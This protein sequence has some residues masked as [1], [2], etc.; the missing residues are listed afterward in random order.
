LQ[1]ATP[2]Q[3]NTGYSGIIKD[4]NDEDYYK[5][6]LTKAG[7]IT[8]SADRAVDLGWNFQVMDK[9]GNRFRS[10]DTK[11]GNNVAGTENIELGLDKGEYYIKVSN[12]SS[13][14]KPY[15]FQVKFKESNYYEKE[16]NNS[17]QTATP[18]ELN[19]AYQGNLQ[20]DNYNH[21]EDWY[22]YSLVKPGNVSVKIDRVAGSSWVVEVLDK[23]G[24]PFT[25]VVTKYDSYASGQET[26]D[27]AL[28]TGQFYIR[29][30]HYTGTERVNY[31][32]IVE[33]T[34]SE[35]YE[36]EFNN[37][38]SS[39]NKVELNQT[40][41]GIIQDEVY[42]EVDFYTFSLSKAGFI[43][44]E[45]DRKANAGWTIEVLDKNGS[46]LS[47]K[48]T[49][50]GSN[51]NGKEQVNIGLPNG[52]Y[53]IKISNYTSSEGIPYSFK[54]MYEKGEFFKREINDDAQT[55][56]PIV[57]NQPYKRLIQ[58]DLYGLDY[59]TFTLSKKEE[60]LFSMKREANKRWE[61]QI[62]NQD[63]NE[64]DYFY[65][66]DKNISNSTEQRDLTLDKGTY[67][68]KITDYYGT[69]NVPYTFKI[70]QKTQRIQGASR[71]DTAIEISKQGWTT[72]NTVVL[73][74]GSDFP[75]ALAGGPLAYYHNVPIL[76]TDGKALTAVTK[77]EI[78][79]LN[80]K[81]VI[82]LG[83]VGAISK[84]VEDELKKSGV[85]I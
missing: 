64:L 41:K 12:Y 27:V 39:A 52:D 8:V 32:F 71:Y 34:Q 43:T 56:N 78:S 48:H 70:Q 79:R 6:T 61:I 3:L 33:F 40:Y 77:K 17:L 69:E 74:K 1:S 19:K 84:A 30:G 63:G 22:T 65:T 53:F 14:L 4:Y 55:A 38:L 24:K 85:S 26:V 76:L 81:K 67:F 16:H 15:Q 2:I 29:I 47:E 28:P 46:V 35:Y 9:E 5:F 73:A 83:S 21:E 57:I 23:T 31:K 25:E 68:I 49:D 50:Y 75:D 82:I 54:V 72:S 66:E 20:E 36:K 37:S 13:E 62:F 44:L 51:A 58:D 80:A 45:M 60:L 11:Y 59:Y 10:F 42:N 18:V 7:N